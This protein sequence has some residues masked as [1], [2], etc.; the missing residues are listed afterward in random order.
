M[1]IFDRLRVRSTD[2]YNPSTAYSLGDRIE[3]SAGYGFIAVSICIGAYYGYSLGNQY[4]YVLGFIFAFA[5]LCCEIMKPIAVRGVFTSL[6][7]LRLDQ[8]AVCLLLA[9]VCVI[10]AW[11][12]TWRSRAPSEVTWPPPARHGSR[13]C[14]RLENSGTGQRP[15]WPSCPSPGLLESL[16]QRLRNCSKP[17]APIA[18]KRWMGPSVDAYAAKYRN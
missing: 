8:A 1:G 2:D 6:R 12:R 5:A 10:Y 14:P 7:R 4:H 3:M 17:R 11:L 15:S 9:L 13:R 18:A 16:R